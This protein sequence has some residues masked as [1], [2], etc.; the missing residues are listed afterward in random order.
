[1]IPIWCVYIYIYTG[2]RIKLILYQQIQPLLEKAI[3]IPFFRVFTTF[4]GFYRIK[5]VL[6][7]LILLSTWVLS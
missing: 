5:V 2:K 1:M 6:V 4:V 7:V 3:D